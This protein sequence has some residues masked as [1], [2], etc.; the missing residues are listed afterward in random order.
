M[1]KLIFLLLSLALHLRLKK[2]IFDFLIPESTH[3]DLAFIFMDRD[4]KRVALKKR[5]TK[6]VEVPKKG[7][8]EKKGYPIASLYFVQKE[9]KY[10]FFFVI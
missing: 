7:Y 8:R 5:S 3:N 10:F 2:E 6:E 4:K 1:T 9:P